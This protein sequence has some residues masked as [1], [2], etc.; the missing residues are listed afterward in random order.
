MSEPG[1]GGA[2]WGAAPIEISVPAHPDFVAAIRAAART[3]A[4]LSDLAV[5]DVEEV[6]LAVDEAATLLLPLVGGAGELLRA[7]FE[8]TDRLLRVALSA[9][10]RPGVEPD[11]SGLP[12]IMLTG[13]DPTVEIVRDGPVVTIVLRRSRSDAEA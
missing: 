2:S 8:V 13:L 7:S 10:S 11:T 3:A 9:P 5:D 1:R 6:Q 4:V 12:W